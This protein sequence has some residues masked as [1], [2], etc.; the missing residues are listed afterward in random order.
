[1]RKQIM[2]VYMDSFDEMD[3]GERLKRVRKQRGL[4]QA[5]LAE[6]S[7]VTTT[8]ISNMENGKS[9]VGVYTLLDI[10]KVLQVGIEE[11]FPEY[12]NVSNVDE[13]ELVNFKLQLGGYTESQRKYI[14]DQI[15]ILIQAIKL[16]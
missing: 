6:L 2:G 10:L 11:I 8:M 15:A 7:G 12:S 16:S 1:M 14:I 9:M 4:T 3:I 13:K 5:K